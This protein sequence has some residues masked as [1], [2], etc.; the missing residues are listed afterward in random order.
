MKLYIRMDKG[1]PVEHP[2]LE[3]NLLEAYQID[4]VTEEFLEKHSLARFEKP[5]VAPDVVILSQDVYEVGDDGVVRPVYETRTLS[6]EEKVDLWIRRPRNI[7]LAQSDWSQLSDSP[8]S[9]AK[10]AEWAAYRQ[11]L[12]DMTTVYA[13]IQ[14]P[15][16]INPPMPPER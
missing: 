14:D 9:A 4:E 16:E 10:K 6:Q 3:S 13:D 7:A 12:R 1:A 11:E 15:S 8:L 5:P 2:I